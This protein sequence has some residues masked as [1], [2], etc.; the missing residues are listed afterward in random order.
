MILFCVAAG[1]ALVALQPAFWVVDRV[2]SV[3]LGV[4]LILIGVMF[5]PG[6]IYSQIT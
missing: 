1:A 3:S 5:T 4:M 2:T 6:L